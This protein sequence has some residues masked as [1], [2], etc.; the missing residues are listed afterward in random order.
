MRTLV[1]AFLAFFAFEARAYADEPKKDQHLESQTDIG[2]TIGDGRFQHRWMTRTLL[3]VRDEFNAFEAHYGLSWRRREGFWFDVTAG[4]AYAGGGELQ[5]HGFVLGSWKRMEFLDRN[6]LVTM[7]GLH[8]FNGR[9]RYD[10][11]YAVDYAV[12]G[13]HV[14]NN[15]RQAAAGFQ[16]GSGRG[17]L[18][19]RF[20]IRISFGITDGMPDHA[21]RFVLSFDFR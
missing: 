19:F 17:L 12:A 21:S 2:G 16:L 20:D 18:P 4:Y 15:G 13:I 11:F 7:E 6:L 1:I 14:L 10:G 9:Y 8:R 3:N 5:G